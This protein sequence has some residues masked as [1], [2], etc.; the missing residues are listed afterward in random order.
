[1]NK[2]SIERVEDRMVVTAAL[3]KNGYTVRSGSQQRPGAKSYDYF[4]EC[5]RSAKEADNRLYIDQEEDQLAVATILV[6]NKYTVKSFSQV[7][8][9]KKQYYYLEYEPNPSDKTQR[10]KEVARDED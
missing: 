2:I 3:I 7:R 1:M 9:G 8:N 5:W 4:L 6:K 10:R